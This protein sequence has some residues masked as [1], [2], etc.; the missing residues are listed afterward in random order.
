MRSRIGFLFSLAYC[1]L[2]HRWVT[3]S[4]AEVEQIRRIH[5]PERWGV[6]HHTKTSEI[7]WLVEPA[8]ERHGHCLPL[9]PDQ[10]R[11]REFSFASDNRPTIT[12]TFGMPSP[13]AASGE[14]LVRLKSAN[15][16]D[17]LLDLSADAEWRKHPGLLQYSVEKIQQQRDAILASWKPGIAYRSD[18]NLGGGLRTPQLGALHAIAAHWSVSRKPGIIVMPTGTG[19]TE[20]MV[21]TALA[22]QSQTVLVI[23]P[24]DA[25]RLQTARKFQTLG[26]LRK[27]GVVPDEFLYPVTGILRGVPKNEADIAIFKCCNVVIATMSALAGATSSILNKIASLCTHLFIDEAHHAPA[28]TWNDLRE[29]FS[30]NL[31]LQFTA[32]PF[33]RDGRRMEGKILYNYPLSKAQ[34]ED[35]FRP[36]RFEQIW[37]WDKDA[38]DHAIAKAA[39]DRLREDL[40]KGYDHIVMAR[41]DSIERAKA[42]YDTI[43]SGHRDLH[44]VV[45]HNKTEGRRKVLDNIKARKHR[46]IICVDMLG[47][48]FDLP[49]LKIAALHDAHRSLG[50]T[51]QFAGRFTRNITGIGPATVIANLA[52]HKVSESLEE[53]YS[54]DADWNRLLPSLSYDAIR[55]H[56]QLSDFVSELKSSVPDDEAEILSAAT[57]QPKTS[58]VVYRADSFWPDGFRR[59]VPRDN[60]IIIWWKIKL[61]TWFC[62]YCAVPKTL[63]G[64]GPKISLIRYTIFTSYS[65]TSGRSCCSSTVRL[66]LRIF[67]LPELLVAPSSKCG[68]RRCSVCL[69]ILSE[70]SFTMQVCFMGGVGPFDS[71]CSPGWTLPRLSIL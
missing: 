17:G 12:F 3:L 4:D 34:A 24:S 23:V 65:M 64:R 61:R 55:P 30:K 18:A 15:V 51:L 70:S 43:Y 2:Y 66:S 37:E 29:R 50:V 45:V 68:V 71:K 16:V 69:E 59:A 21:A 1:L 40:T 32:T 31:V 39:L 25:L 5:L 6:R 22:S 38:A 7:G 13:A 49:Q 52:D 54:E 11:V 28:E 60:E 26:V 44:P 46:V 41:T 48:G 47:E 62:L 56:V 42:L 58:T 8:V 20:V 63:D 57:L 27:I 14:S 33:R 35:Y 9:R 36:I 19:K 67:L 53:L 10:R